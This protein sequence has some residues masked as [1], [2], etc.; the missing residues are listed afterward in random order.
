MRI[1]PAGNTVGDAV[2][3]VPLNA[4][5]MQK[6][7]RPHKE[8][9]SNIRLEPECNYLANRT[10]ATVPS[11]AYRGVTVMPNASATK[12]TGTIVV[13]ASTFR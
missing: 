1:C 10:S 6:K 13:E 12:R 9:V 5:Q 7:K 11:S 2:L 3:S 8:S 4:T